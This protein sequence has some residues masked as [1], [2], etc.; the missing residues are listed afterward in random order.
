MPDG[1]DSSIS[2]RA[3]LP[4]AAR[5]CCRVR[6]GRPWRVSVRVHGGGQV[7]ERAEQR[8]VEVKSTDV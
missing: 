1:T 3:P 5:I 7:A 4:S 6:S 8:A 2:R